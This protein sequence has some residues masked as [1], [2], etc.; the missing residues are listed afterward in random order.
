MADKNKDE[1]Q[2]YDSDVD[3]KMDF[4]EDLNISP[5]QHINRAIIYAQRALLKD[6]VKSAFLQYR[7]I[8]EHIETLCRSAGFLDDEYNGKIEEY[9]KSKEYIEEEENSIKS[10]KLAN[11]KL[12]LLMDI[13]FKAQPITEPLR[14]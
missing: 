5:K 12:G 7:I 6:D 13:F 4:E 14:L 3:I 8:V 10:V 11:K 2:K 9:K 1:S